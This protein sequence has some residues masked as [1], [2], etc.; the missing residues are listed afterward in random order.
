MKKTYQNGYL[1]I[2][3]LR[4]D[5]IKKAKFSLTIK[6][7]KETFEDHFK[8]LMPLNLDVLYLNSLGKLDVNELLDEQYTYDFVSVMFDMGNKKLREAI[9]LKGFTVNGKEYVRYKRSAGSARSGNCLFIKKPLFNVMDKW[10]MCG[11]NL[12]E[13]SKDLVSYESYKAL[14]LSSLMK[15]LPLKPYNILFVKDHEAIL[16]N[17]KVVRVSLDKDNNLQVEEKECDIRNKI[18]DGEGLLDKDVFKEQGLTSKGMMLLRNRFFKSCVFNT[19]LQE[20]FKENNI[21]KVDQLN[22]YTFAKNIK[23]IKMVVTESSIKFVK[24][25]SGGFTKEN[26]KRWCDEISDDKGYSTFGIVKTDKKSRYFKGDMVET[27]YQLLNTLHLSDQDVRALLKLNMEYIEKIRDVTKNPEYLRLYVK[28]EAHVERSFIN[29]INEYDDSEDIKTEDI[30][31]SLAE[32]VID[33]S[34]YGYKKLVCDTLLDVNRDVLKTKTFK[35][36][37]YEETINTLKMRLYSGRVLVHGSYM[38]LFGNPYELL[39][40]IV[41][42]FNG[43]SAFLHKNEVCTRFFSDK[44]QLVGSRA[45]HVTMSNV[46]YSKNVRSMEIEKWFNLTKEI[47]IVDAIENNIQHR[48]NGADYD[49]D[50][51]LLTDDKVIVDAA[52]EGYDTTFLI[53]YMDITPNLNSQLEYVKDKAKNLLLNYVYIDDKVANNDIGKI[54]NNSQ[55]LNSY[56][57]DTLNGKNRENKEKL[58]EIFREICKLAVLSNIEIDS[59]KRTFLCDVDEEQKKVDLFIKSLKLATTDEVNPKGYSP[60]FFYKLRNKKAAIGYVENYIR[61]NE[62]KRFKTTM[63]YVWNYV[64][65]YKYESKIGKFKDKITFSDLTKAKVVRAVSGGQ[66]YGVA[67][68][69]RD[70]IAELNDDLMAYRKEKPDIDDDIRKR[71]FKHKVEKVVSS[72]SKHLDN[73][74][75]IRLVIKKIDKLPEE[76]AKKAKEGKKENKR[77]DTFYENVFL[78]FFFIIY[79]YQV[80]RLGKESARDFLSSLFC[81][82]RPVLA[83]RRTKGKFEYEL[84]DRFKYTKYEADADKLL[85]AIFAKI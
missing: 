33:E 8:E 57:W 75:L 69:I 24:L 62:D 64:F 15:L 25:A 30:D 45:P 79:Y 61:D 1:R 4:A 42:K 23:D 77:G 80:H 32:D 39:L 83:L 7:G 12:E 49:S 50:T 34:P 63:D 21:T 67:E 66:N 71:D 74:D 51:V 2:I 46:L 58:P 9:Y 20:W 13:R 29:Q 22:G 10:S 65:S 82:E 28:G 40:N 72:F 59:A 78:L 52:S 35:Q 85:R 5:E 60:L 56:Y 70:T 54:I 17:Q 6:N 76:D 37:V 41:K 36:F 47:V 16:K 38:T 19:N 43:K 81:S 31:E 44:T 18:W 68:K 53:P 14:S 11:L 26:L 27:T 48:L 55:L 73:E 84:F 3:Q